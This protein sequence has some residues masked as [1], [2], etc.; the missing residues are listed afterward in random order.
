MSLRFITG[1]AGSG[2]THR[3]LEEIAEILR[4]S[5]VGP[6]LI[7]LVPEQASFQTEYALCLR[8]GLRG[9]LRAEI[10]SFRRLAYRVLAEVGGG[11]ARP[12]IGDLAK[13]M[14]LRRFLE[15]RRAELKTFNRIPAVPGFLDRLASAISEFKVYGVSPQTLGS[16]AA[17]FRAT[18]ETGL[19]DKMDDLCL[20]YADLQNALSGRYTDPDDYLDLL[21]KGIP[22]SSLVSKSTVWV[23]GF[24]GF[25]PQEYAVLEALMRHAKRVNVALCLDGPESSP[26][27]TNGDVFHITRETYARITE[28]AVRQGIPVEPTV[29]LAAKPRFRSSPALIH[30]E[31]NLARATALPFNSEPVNLTLTAAADRRAEV[32]AVGREIIHLCRD[33]S[34]RFRE[35]S[36]VLRQL[37]LYRDLIETVFTDH[38]IPF[39]IDFKRQVMHHP[40]VE[41]V[42]SALDIVLNRWAYDPVFRYLKTDLAP[43]DRESVDILE[44]YVLAY[45]IQGFRWTDGPDWG[46]RP[47]R[48]LDEADTGPSAGEIAF[49]QRINRIRRA[50]TEALAAF[51]REVRKAA[52]V[53][54]LTASLVNLLLRLDVPGRLQAWSSQL[55]DGGKPE[56]A[57]EYAQLWNG[58]IDLFDQLVDCLGE[59]SVSLEEYARILDAG[60]E[61][62]HLALIPPAIDQVLVGTLDRSRNPDIRAAFVLGVNDGILPARHSEHGLFTDQEREKLAQGGVELAPGIWQRHLEEQFLVYIAFTRASEYLWVSYALSEDEGR[63]L[64]PSILI[65]RL[66]SIFPTVREVVFTA[67]PGQ[68]VPNDLHY[69]ARA[70]TVIPFLATRL[71]DH[72]RGHPIAGIWWD[73]YNWLAAHPDLSART[74]SVVQ[75]LFYVN[76]EPDL[77]AEQAVQLYGSP[78]RTSVS[79]IERLNSCP[80]AH[81]SSYGLRLR[82]RQVYKLGA[83]DLGEFLHAT[84]RRFAELADLKVGDWALLTAS[85][86][87]DLAA[88]VVAE[89]TPALQNE[90]LLSTARYRHLGSKVQKTVA[91]SA[92]VLTEH[93]RQGRF[94]PVGL[95]LGFG[96]GATLAPAPVVLETGQMVQLEGRIDRLDVARDG[97]D[98][99]LRVIDYKSGVTRP[100]LKS[101][102]HGLQIQL[103]AYLDVALSCA[104]QLLGVEAKPG[105]MLYFRAYN[106]LLPSCGPLEDAEIEVKILEKMRMT[107]LLVADPGVV[108]L[109]DANLVP[110]RISRLLPVGI[111]GKGTF[112]QASSLITE[113][114]LDDL[115]AHLHHLIRAAGQRIFGGAVDI[116]PAVLGGY[117][118]CRFCPFKPVCHFDPLLGGNAYRQLPSPGPD[119]LWQH[120]RS[121]KREG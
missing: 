112:Y 39:F 22:V 107:G 71:R 66:R 117:V 89:L 104:T 53:T 27:A 73:V 85:D 35:I 18:G 51:E 78:L 21:T 56:L 103:L 2:K 87:D 4:V 111:T 7:F 26:E 92:L 102:Y 84:L 60:L 3:C 58:I 121:G 9:S 40:V 36:I 96:S 82:E 70:N 30:L 19:S 65:D 95:E 15:S 48:R 45:G 88:E 91:R 94:H 86:C 38:G 115:R 63:A 108:R 74:A 97:D 11:A 109:M 32:E 106:P 34:Y 59:E 41:L 10:L 6:P 105:G 90:I 80:F 114:Q 100:D 75:S 61:S 17:S 118:A 12:H 46:Y 93:A 43:V 33:R 44:N 62:L 81:F 120:L 116:S 13:C 99:Y 119:E 76:R 113:E 42:R 110:G 49:L 57:R 25:T 20:L 69:I 14:L 55:Q 8:P 83:P 24:S 54:Q 31:Q 72:L 16:V 23:D 1:R 52:D 79:R 77:L 37:D 98:R 28:M 101:V 47:R 68:T 50:A 29:Q 67:E 64:G 5:P